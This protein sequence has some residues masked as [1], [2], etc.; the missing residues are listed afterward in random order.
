[1]IHG[2]NTGV[3]ITTFEQWW[4]QYSTSAKAFQISTSLHIIE[5]IMFEKEGEA[6]AVY[7]NGQL[8]E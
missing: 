7:L 5:T 8:V 3:Q 1:M 4:L 6:D 2:T